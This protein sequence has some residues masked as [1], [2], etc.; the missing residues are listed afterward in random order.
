VNAGRLPVLWLYGP[1]GVGKTTAGWRLFARLGAD[2]IPIGYVDIDQLGMCYAAPTPDHWS[3]EPA[4][5]PGRHLVKARTLDAVVANFRAAGARGLIVSGVADPARGPEVDLVPGAELT[6]CRLRAEPAVLRRRLTIRGRPTD[7]V[8]DALREARTLDRAR[9]TDPVVD[10]TG[11]TVDDVLRSVRDLTG[12][13]DRV[14]SPVPATEPVVQARAAV[15]GAVLWLCGV[16][17]VGKSTVG[18]EL[19]RRVRAAGHRAAFVDL[20][21]VGFLRPVP[22]GDPGNH[23]LKAANLGAVWRSFH[24]AGATCLIAV[25]PVDRAGAV[26]AYAAALPGATLTVCRL[27]AARD[28]VTR[29]VM[30]RGGGH[31]PAW[32]MAGD[33]LIGR[34]ARVLAGIARRAADEAEALDRAG[35]G[36]LRVDTDGRA[37]PDIA[38]EILART[39]WPL[40]G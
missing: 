24:D 23:R 39:G 32:G 17:A 1:G 35:V 7:E 10:T 40:I 19:Y 15:P 6:L 29:R 13:P 37:V 3:P 5:D 36:D 25:G 22:A 30:L 4:S 21:Q 26:P 27:H 31:A 18:W 8:D 28:T 2:G 16:T 14:G 20:D 38:G 11:R 9:L 33:E 12:W 34:P